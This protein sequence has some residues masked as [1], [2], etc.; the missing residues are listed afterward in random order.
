MEFLKGRHIKAGHRTQSFF[1]CL[2]T[3]PLRV[4]R[5]CRSPS[6]RKMSTTV[7]MG[8]WS[9]TVKGLKFRMRLSFSGCGLLAGSSGGS[10]V[11]YMMELLTMPSCLCLA[12]SRTMTKKKNDKTHTK[13]LVLNYPHLLLYSIS[14]RGVLRANSTVIT[15]TSAKH[16]WTWHP[17]HMLWEGGPC[18]D[19]NV[20]CQYLARWAPTN[21]VLCKCPLFFP[22]LQSTPK[23]QRSFIL[24]FTP[25]H[26]GLKF[27][28]TRNLISLPN[29]LSTLIFTN[30]LTTGLN[31]IM[32]PR[33]MRNQ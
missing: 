17:S 2:A 25:S 12:F 30:E 14:P 18:C 20:H 1:P 11:K 27:V 26:H 4:T 10:S 16:L 23:D 31:G 29:N 28:R 32:N 15:S 13:H 3:H 33:G 6:F 19:K 8:V 9:V 5:H 22:R 21:M 7:S 24:A